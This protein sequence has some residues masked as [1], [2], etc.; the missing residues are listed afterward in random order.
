MMTGTRKLGKPKFGE[1]LFGQPTEKENEE[2]S[3]T[4]VLT[5]N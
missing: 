3:I 4:E 1:V 5:N 2:A